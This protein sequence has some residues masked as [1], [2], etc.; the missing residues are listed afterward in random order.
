MLE[1]TGA[2]T[3]INAMRDRA[4]AAS[5][6]QRAL[7]RLVLVEAENNLYLLRAA[8]ID[9]PQARG[10]NAPGLREV[11][12]RLRT[13]AVERLI[14]QG[15]LADRF[16]EGVDDSVG[17][18]GPNGADDEQPSA[19]FVSG[20]VVWLY[21]KIHTIQA[22]AHTYDLA[23]G[24][25]LPDVVAVQFNTRLRRIRE[26]SKELVKALH[27]VEAMSLEDRIRVRLRFWLEDAKA[28]FEALV[29]VVR[30][31]KRIPERASV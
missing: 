20:H 25:S 12:K 23:D 1:L 13:E 26:A 8:R 30:R 15:P 18:P 3:E 5:R 24:G 10:A 6:R 16:F 29:A 2:I 14:A 31:R 9:D 7:L 4:V 28:W 21:R 22:L 27:T 11:A 19:R 17:E